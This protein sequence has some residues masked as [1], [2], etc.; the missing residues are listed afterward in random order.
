MEKLFGNSRRALF[1]HRGSIGL[2]SLAP[3]SVME[4]ASQNIGPTNSDV[5]GLVLINPTLA[6]AGN[7]QSSP[8]LIFA[9]QGWGTSLGVGSRDVRFRMDVLPVQGA[10]NPTST[11]QI[12]SSINGAAYTNRVTVGSD[13][14]FSQIG[15]GVTNS[16]QGPLIVASGVSITNAPQI[17]FGN[18]TS[19]SS[20]RTTNSGTS[21]IPEFISQSSGSTAGAVALSI[22]RANLNGFV[23]CA[24]NGTRQIARVSLQI[25]NLTNTAGSESGDLIIL[26]QSGGTAMSQKM[27]ISGLGNIVAGAESALATGAT[28]GFLYIP[29]VA[30]TPSGTPTAYTAKV[31]LVF[32]TT[33]SKLYIYTGGSWK[34]GTTPGVFI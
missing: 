30:G 14:T 28:D 34:G 3:A 22:D 20:Y 23:L 10:S 32:D 9:C 24:A 8:G 7:Q 4:I 18:T 33:N 25:T 26:T 29:T 11:L 21:F 16:F 12:C 6:V 5:L 19:S 2:G 1:A 13:G 15:S 31:P 17:N 27:R